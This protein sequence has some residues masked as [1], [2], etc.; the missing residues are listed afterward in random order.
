ML[1]CPSGRNITTFQTQPIGQQASAQ[2][3]GTR[4]LAEHR[5]QYD[6]GARQT[7]VPIQIIIGSF[8]S[9][10]T[11]LSGL[12]LHFFQVEVMTTSLRHVET[13]QGTDTSSA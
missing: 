1:L 3:E 10:V 7:R 9:S 6:L 4:F 8:A 2:R 12:S 5:K 13:I 11:L